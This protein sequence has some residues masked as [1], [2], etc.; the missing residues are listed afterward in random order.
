METI[1]SKFRTLYIL[2]LIFGYF[3]AIVC[4][5]ICLKFLNGNYYPAKE[6]AALFFIFVILLFVLLGTYDFLKIT[7]IIV[8]KNTIEIQCFLGLK[9][10]IIQYHEITRINRHKSFLQGRTGQISDGF[11]LSEIVLSDKSSFI[12][13]PDKFGNYSL[14]LFSI[15]KNRD[16][17][18]H[19]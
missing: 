9:R 17:I 8:K 14:L 10:K 19:N 7:K 12:V 6:K 11:H 16:S 13:S 18:Q 1:T 15:N 3:A 2:K 5:G 4:I